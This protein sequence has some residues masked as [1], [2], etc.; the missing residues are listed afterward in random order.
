[1]SKVE[2]NVESAGSRRYSNVLLEREG[3]IGTIRLNRPQALNALSSELMT[4]LLDALK[5]LESEQAISCIIITGSE[6]VFS[7]GADIK[8]LAEQNSVEALRAA[9][10]ERFDAI[11]KISK[12][13]IAAISG[14]CF[15][16]GLEL[17]MI[18]DI[19]VASESAKL[20]QPEINIGV[21][22]GAGGTQR[23]SRIIG[24]YRAMDMILTGRQISS[25]EAHELGL[26]SR[27]VPDESLLSEAKK[28]A[29]EIA[30]KS[31][32]AIKIAKECVLKSYETS[33][34]EGLQFERRNF[35]LLLSSE[36]KK[37]GMRAFLEKRKPTFKGQ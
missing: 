26:V 12:P 33:L 34:S 29:N 11:Q 21:M 15:G 32:L 37:E 24:K 8:E 2:S 23:L 6:K 19:I 31:P 35:Y 18:C 17:A 4:E 28:I 22:P 10:L 20:G 25:K 13:I 27:V 5:M 3:Q 9:N 30:S 1:L 7:A 16:G 14:F 36:D